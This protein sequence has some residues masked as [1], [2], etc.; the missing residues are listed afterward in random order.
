MVRVNDLPELFNVWLVQSNLT[1]Y[2]STLAENERPVDVQEF[3]VTAS[4]EV[5]GSTAA[6]SSASGESAAPAPPSTTSGQ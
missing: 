5:P 3:S 4:V 2:P 6:T 1:L